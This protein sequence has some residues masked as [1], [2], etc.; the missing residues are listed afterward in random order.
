M[1]SI[2][3]IARL[4]GVSPATVSRII[5]NSG[6]A[7][8]DARKRV[9]E[10]VQKCNYQPN[11]QARSLVT[12]K[13]KQ[14]GLLVPQ[15]DNTFFIRVIT[16]TGRL[17]RMKG[18]NI[19]LCH[20]DENEQ[21]ERNF[22][23]ILLAQR[24]AGIIAAPVGIHHTAYDNVIKQIPT[25]FLSRHFKNYESNWVDLDNYGASYNIMSS[26]IKSGN[27]KIVVLS[28]ERKTSSIE[29]RLEGMWEACRDFNLSKDDIHI[30]NSGISIDD[31]Y[32]KIAGFW[33][34]TQDVTAVYALHTMPALGA[35]KALME[36]GYKIP[37][38]VSLAAFNGME[39]SQY[40]SLFSVSLTGNRHPT[41]EMCEKA[42]GILL[43][44]MDEFKKNGKM[45]SV[46]QIV[47]PLE[48]IVKESSDFYR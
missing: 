19:L 13:S 44:S 37:E 40:S 39:D 1:L 41:K 43:N 26:L 29:D 9:M 17:L 22:L 11:A 33:E 38:D 35:M 12:Q 45:Q 31:A 18:Y 30:I 8:E 7:S 32:Q 25:V 21:I 3:D 47:Y 28:H 6:Y 42:I 36:R 16:E 5:N 2:K 24:V 15:I 23:D 14:I 20:T 34:T 48:L 46:E 10:V 4:S 27:K